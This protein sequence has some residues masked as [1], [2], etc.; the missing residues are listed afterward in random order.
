MMFTEVTGCLWAS[1]SC[2]WSSVVPVAGVLYLTYLVLMPFKPDENTKKERVHEDDVSTDAGES[3]TESST[4]SSE[5]DSDETWTAAH[6]C[7][8][9]PV[10]SRDMLMACRPKPP[11]GLEMPRMYEV[12]PRPVEELLEEEVKQARPTPPWLKRTTAPQNWTS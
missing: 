11:P 10:Y 4:K 9:G 5:A 8:V 3:D 7:A 1:T 2:L 6:T 12:R